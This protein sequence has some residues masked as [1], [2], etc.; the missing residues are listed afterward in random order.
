MFSNGRIRY[1]QKQLQEN[2]P[3]KISKKPIMSP[4]STYLTKYHYLNNMELSILIKE[5][6]LW[7]KCQPE[8]STICEVKLIQGDEKGLTADSTDC[9]FRLWNLWIALIGSSPIK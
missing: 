1:N 5:T 6:N 8:N 9:P 3:A 7:S 2:Q 4:P